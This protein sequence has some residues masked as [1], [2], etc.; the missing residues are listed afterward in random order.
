M[1]D[2]R[3]ND[4]LECY[5]EYETLA[6]NIGFTNLTVEFIPDYPKWNN[7]DDYIDSMHV[8]FQGEFDPTK[9][10]NHTL[11]EIKQEYSSGP[12]VQ[13]DLTLSEVKLPVCK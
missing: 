3:E 2:T 8:W 9:F 12:V 13:S 6:S 10:N 4:T 11:E 1:D 7:L 5:S